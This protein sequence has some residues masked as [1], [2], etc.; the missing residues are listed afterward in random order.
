MIKESFQ[1]SGD[2]LS[3]TLNGIGTT[4]KAFGKKIVSLSHSFPYM[5]QNGVNFFW[6]LYE[7]FIFIIHDV[8]LYITLGLERTFYAWHR[9]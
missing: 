2:R 3:L 5:K 7:L 8:K 6:K 4:D 1:V 9:Y